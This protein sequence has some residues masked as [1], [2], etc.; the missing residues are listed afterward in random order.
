MITKVKE[1]DMLRPVLRLFPRS[2]YRRFVEVPLGRKRIDLVCEWRSEASRTVAVEL[3]I[4]HWRQALWQAAMNFQLSHESYVAIWHEF[5]G[6]IEPH[7]HLL[8]EYGIG[9]INV[10]PSGA[11]FVQHS[12]DRIFRLA[13][14][15][16]RL[17]YE[18]LAKEV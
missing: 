16:K 15:H 5:I 14:H 11:S 1:Q 17:L 4:S 7:R 6:R 8:L 10:R 3:K 12:Q 18:L 9:L 2:R 13:R